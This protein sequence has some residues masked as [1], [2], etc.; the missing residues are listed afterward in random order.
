[1]R[2]KTILTKIKISGGRPSTILFFIWFQ[3]LIL[4]EIEGI[5]A[6]FWLLMDLNTWFLKR[7]SPGN[8]VFRGPKRWF[9]G[10]GIPPP[11]WNHLFG[12]LNAR[13]PGL[14]HIKNHVFRFIIFKITKIK[15][16]K[17]IPTAILFF[18]WFQK[19]ILVEIE[20]I[21]ATFWLLMDLNTWFLKRKSPGNSVFRGPK[22]WFYG[23]GIPPPP[24]NHL[25]GPLNARFPGLF[26]KLSWT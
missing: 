8:S 17:G 14:F 12:P 16:S 25:F 11:P 1:M 9:Y 13:F 2:K 26:H 7:K 18:I 3:K 24:W 5:F 6:T 10:G 15:I 23:G 19:L 21:F 22:R 20:G 4:V